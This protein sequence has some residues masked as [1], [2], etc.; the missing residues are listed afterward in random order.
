M[1]DPRKRQAAGQRS[2]GGEKRRTG[3][4]QWR[5]PRRGEN[6]DTSGG[7]IEAGEAGIWATCARGREGK[8]TVELQDIFAEY[9][10]KLYG[11]LVDDETPK[12]GNGDDDDEEDIEAEIKR[13][14]AD[15]RK[16][17]KRALFHPIKIDSPCVLFFKTRQPIEPVSFVRRICS[18][19]IE[20]SSLKRSRWVQRLTP[21]TSMGKAT[22]KGLD[23]VAQTVLAPHFHARC[24]SPKKFAIR[25]TIRNHSTLTRDGVIKQLADVVGP[26]H[27]VDLKHYDLMIIVEIY[28]NICGM[29]VVGSDFD[30]LNRYNLAEIYDPTPKVP[31]AKVP[32]PKVPAAE[33][34]EEPRRDESGGGATKDHE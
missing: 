21:M 24:D 34:V 16:P 7:L 15:M 26:A 10:E 29:S 6:R 8:C 13:E 23:E 28:K 12:Q 14:V 2:D 32:T 17:T 18:D 3:P 31:T 30:K 11:S 33:L 20:S 25:P 1:D 4:T 22:E 19:A 27:Q 9:A 5:A